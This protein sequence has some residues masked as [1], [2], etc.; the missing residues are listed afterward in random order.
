MHLLTEKKKTKCGKVAERIFTMAAINR[1]QF[2][3]VLA[4]SL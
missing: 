1:A 4:D 2:I 3:A